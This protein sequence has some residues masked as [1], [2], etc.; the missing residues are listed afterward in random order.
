[1]NSLRSLENRQE[2][3]KRTWMFEYIIKTLLG[4]R[5]AT[6]N[7]I[8]PAQPRLTKNERAKLFTIEKKFTQIRKTES[9][10]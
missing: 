2:K 5:T 9:C 6:Q 4:S 8:E 10:L 3:N 7:N 1:M